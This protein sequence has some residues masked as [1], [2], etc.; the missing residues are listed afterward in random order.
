MNKYKAMCQSHEMPTSEINYRQKFF[1]LGLGYS[2]IKLIQESLSAHWNNKIIFGFIDKEKSIS[3]LRAY[4]PGTQ[5][6][7]CTNTNPTPRDYYH[8]ICN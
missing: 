3:E 8:Q 5:S 7:I 1:I 6:S 2:V 4:P